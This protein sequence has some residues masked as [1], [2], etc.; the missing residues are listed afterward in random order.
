MKQADPS[1]HLPEFAAANGLIHR[2]ELLLGALMASMAPALVAQEG[3]APPPWTLT[4]GRPMSG[5]GVPS[6]W[7]KNVQRGFTLPPGR[8][9]TGASRTPLHL[10]EGTITPNGLHFERHPNGVPDIDPARHE[11]LVHGLVDRPL[12]FTLDNLL[13]YPLQSHIRFI[14]C[15]GN[16]GGGAAPAPTQA[17][18]GTLH[19]LVSC[20]QWTG[21]PLSILLQEAGIRPNASWVIAEGADA[22]A[23]SRSIPLAKCLDD[24]MIA[25]YQN[26]EAVRPEQGF[27]MRLLLPGF[28]GNTNIK[29]LRRLRL[30]DKPAN[31]KD[32][33]SKYSELMPDGRARQFMLEMGPKSVILKP[34]FG[35]SMQGRGYYE[36]SGIAWSGA[37]RIRRVEI[38]ADGGRTWAE[39]LLE[40]P[41]LPKALTR[42]RLAWRWDGSPL[43][44]LSRATDEAGATQP[45]RS[46]WV[47]QYA[48]GQ[49][50]H[51][52]AIQTWD[53]DA[54]GK[55][56][57][58]YT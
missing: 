11:L 48:P 15:A 21:V 37:G 57:N 55:V 54:A 1:E 33:T 36:I 41:V 44:L 30:T 35:M 53:I 34:S 5:Y 56:T 25:L 26:G 42:F 14:E 7:R 28:Q 45:P 31:T 47:K 8:P 4:P 20:A 40:G 23:L 17:D 22:A 18:A 10:L 46:E 6:E 29:W 9:G 51:Y 12:T 16:S 32:E 2:R 38:S 43:R 52:N 19:G 27:P 39:A 24:A 3:A 58:A 13:R 49:G 50:Y